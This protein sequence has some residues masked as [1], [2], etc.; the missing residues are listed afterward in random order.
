M[1][2]DEF[3]RKVNSECNKNFELTISNNNLVGDVFD[4]TECINDWSNIITDRH[5]AELLV[6]IVEQIEVSFMN[7]SYGLYRQAFS[8]QRLSLELFFGSIYFSTNKLLYLEWAKGGY[9]NSWST[10]T[11]ENSGIMSIRFANA[12]CP[13]LSENVSIFN[14]NAKKYYR[15]LSEYV[16]GNYDTFHQNATL[17][18]NETLINTYH[19][20]ISEFK[21][22]FVFTLVM[23]YFHEMKIT[24]IEKIY[25]TTLD[26]HHIDAIRK[27][28]KHMEE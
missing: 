14:L 23:R 6:R 21:K 18:K 8:S 15:T 19:S 25:S 24:E 22:L 13:E 9:D 5:I 10:L 16:H 26:L 12:F 28:F 2:A 11:C 20:I 3:Y 4:L 17:E 7:L 27:L 1:T